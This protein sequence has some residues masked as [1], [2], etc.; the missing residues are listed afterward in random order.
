MP[1]P[2][3][4]G[5]RQADLIPLSKCPTIAI[6]KSHRL[7]VLAEQI[8]WTELVELVE[9]IRLS[10][11]KNGAGRQHRNHQEQQVRLQPPC[12]ALRPQDGR[13]GAAGGPRLQPQ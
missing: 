8:D 1:E 10:R 5:S 7:A 4:G 3:R 6:E 13:R 2:T 11:V 12:C 9:E